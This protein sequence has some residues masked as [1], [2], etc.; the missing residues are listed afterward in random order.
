[1]FFAFSINYIRTFS[2]RFIRIVENKEEM[3]TSRYWT[4]TKKTQRNIVTFED[5][6]KCF[7]EILFFVNECAV[8]EKFD[9]DAAIYSDFFRNLA[10]N[11]YPRTMYA[12]MKYDFI[13]KML[14]TREIIF[15]P[16]E[17]IIG[18]AAIFG[19]FLID[20]NLSLYSE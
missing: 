9:S 7:G 4:R 15:V 19:Q 18:Y 12:T 6:G 5:E 1:M 16:V 3:F 13:R 11:R 2:T 8:I 14:P 20:Y 10:P 17:N